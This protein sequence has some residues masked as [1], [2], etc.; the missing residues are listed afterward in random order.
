MAM[1]KLGTVA[2]VGLLEAVADTEETF[3]GE[4]AGNAALTLRENLHLEG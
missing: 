1:T 4:I 2:D 3:V